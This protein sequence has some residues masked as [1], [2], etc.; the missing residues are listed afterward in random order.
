MVNYN[1]KLAAALRLRHGTHVALLQTAG[2]SYIVARDGRSGRSHD[3]RAPLVRL[4]QSEPRACRHKV[5]FTSHPPNQA[6][7]GM[8]RMCGVR[9]IGYLQGPTER[10]HDMRRSGFDDTPQTGNTLGYRDWFNR[11][12][13][14]RASIERWLKSQNISYQWSER[15]RS[16]T[17]AGPTS[18]D[19]LQLVAALTAGEPDPVMQDIV[20]TLLAFCVVE[21]VHGRHRANPGREREHFGQNIGSVLVDGKGRLVAWGV[22]HDLGNPTLHAEVN[23]IQ[24]YQAKTGGAQLPGNGTIY[25]TL[26]PCEMCAG[27]LHVATPGNFRVVCGQSDP[28]LGWTVLRN[29]SRRSMMSTARGVILPGV[30]WTDLREARLGGRPGF[31]DGLVQGTPQ[32]PIHGDTHALLYRLAERYLS[33]DAL[34]QWR[35]TLAAF[36]GRVRS[37]TGA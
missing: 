17:G 34:M 7:K 23:I 1:M 25:T 14:E 18:G 2:D 36:L 9:T 12:H 30:S 3:A 13:L 8:A 6:E 33:G 35:G 26:E 4:L 29:S 27:L 15:H 21:V 20:G 37:G 16:L 22:T 11:P 5:V 32:T 24:Y 28:N 31:A 10:W 19:E